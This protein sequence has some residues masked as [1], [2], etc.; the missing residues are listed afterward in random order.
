MYLE[1]QKKNQIPTTGDNKKSRVNKK[2]ATQQ[3]KDW[4]FAMQYM[5]QTLRA[6]ISTKSN[7]YFDS[8]HPHRHTDA[9]SASDCAA[10]T[11]DDYTAWTSISVLCSSIKKN[12]HIF[13]QDLSIYSQFHACMH[14]RHWATLFSYEYI[15]LLAVAATDAIP[16]F[17]PLFVSVP[18]TS[19]SFSI[20]ISAV[21]Y[22]TQLLS[23]FSHY[24]VYH[25]VVPSLCSVLSFVWLG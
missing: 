5:Q 20:I 25:N 17:T 22:C 23:I 13:S 1:E 24:F 15:M 14:L 12:I 4:H 7:T 21:L 9:H 16:L 3:K 11:M 6:Q 10:N 19:F 18:A 2:E 8:T